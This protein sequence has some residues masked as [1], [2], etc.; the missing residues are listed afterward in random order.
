LEFP[1]DNLL[2]IDGEKEVHAIEGGSLRSDDREGAPSH[3]ER[4]L[5]ALERAGVEVT[6]DGVRLTKRRR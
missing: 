6:E 3:L 2:A 4:V 1:P 5:A